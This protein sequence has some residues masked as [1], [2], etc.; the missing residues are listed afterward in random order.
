[1]THLIRANED[2]ED[3]KFIQRARVLNHINLYRWFYTFIVPVTFYVLGTK[4]MLH[5]TR[6][7][8]WCVKRTF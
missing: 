2:L 3:G 4:S 8:Q 5:S 1:M 6:A 7:I